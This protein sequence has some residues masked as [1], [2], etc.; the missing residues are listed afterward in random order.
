MRMK[1]MMVAAVALIA[2]SMGVPGMLTG[3][4][5]PPNHD[6]ALDVQLLPGANS[7]VATLELDPD[8]PVIEVTLET[9]EATL[10]FTKTGEN[11]VWVAEGELVPDV[12]CYPVTAR[13][14]LATM[15]STPVTTP[16]GKVKKAKKGKGKKGQHE[17]HKSSTKA[18]KVKAKQTKGGSHTT[19]EPSLGA[20]VVNVTAQSCLVQDCEEIM[21]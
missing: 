11:G 19:F 12:F 15:T 20:I 9:D 18:K 7:L 3:N 2:L 13:V 4:P 1:L 14:T 17:K 21:N 16:V 10:Y 5:V 8:A 6:I